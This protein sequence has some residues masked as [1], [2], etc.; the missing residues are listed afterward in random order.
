MGKAPVLVDKGASSDVDDTGGEAAWAVFF[1]ARNCESEV[2]ALF[3]ESA[4]IG[5]RS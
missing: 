3:D 1:E 5:P 4:T 2:C